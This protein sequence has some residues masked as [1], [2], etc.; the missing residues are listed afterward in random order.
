[1]QN[2]C[3]FLPQFTRSHVEKNWAQKYICGEKMTNMRSVWITLTFYQ[4]D[5]P[6][7]FTLY[8]KQHPLK[9]FH[10]LSKWKCPPLSLS[11]ITIQN[12]TWEPSCSLRKE[13]FVSSFSRVVALRR[14]TCSSSSTWS[15]FWWWG[16][17]DV[18]MK[19]K[20]L[21]FLKDRER[22]RF[23]KGNWKN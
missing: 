4:G 19:L 12:L 9:H 7:I 15:S 23:F 21:D 17:F 22:I 8:A 20:G 10:F 16:L 1:M 11:M 3:I 2:L 13:I 14:N 18:E 5:R 6:T